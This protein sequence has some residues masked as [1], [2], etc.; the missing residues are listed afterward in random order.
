MVSMKS[1]ESESDPGL[2]PARRAPTGTA[3]SLPGLLPIC[4]VGTVRG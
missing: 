3:T 2:P 4:R 1:T